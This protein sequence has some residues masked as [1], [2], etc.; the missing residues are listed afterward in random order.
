MEKLDLAGKTIGRAL[1]MRGTLARDLSESQRHAIDNAVFEKGLKNEGDFNTVDCI[2]DF[3]KTQYDLRTVKAETARISSTATVVVP[4]DI[5]MAEAG[6]TVTLI[7]A[8]LIR[9]DMKAMLQF[10]TRLVGLDARNYREHGY[11]DGEK[12]LIE[13]ERAFDFDSIT[14]EIKDLQ[15]GIDTLDGIIQGI[16]STTKFS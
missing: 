11:G 1:R 16:D 6:S 13:R 14:K 15:D 3:I 9:D 8:V 7:Q 12:A 4:L 5:P 10:Y 2:A